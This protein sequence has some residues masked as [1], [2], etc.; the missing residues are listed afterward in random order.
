MQSRFS[1]IEINGKGLDR[2]ERC[3][4]LPLKKRAFSRKLR[5]SSGEGGVHS[6]PTRP[7]SCAWADGRH[8]SEIWCSTVCSWCSCRG[9]GKVDADNADNADDA[10]GAERA[11]DEGEDE[12]GGGAPARKEALDEPPRTLLLESD[13]IRRR[14]STRWSAFEELGGRLGGVGGGELGGGERGRCVSID[15]VCTRERGAARAYNKAMQVA[16][17]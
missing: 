15:C 5:A 8:L 6:T 12:D 17:G 1:A 10:D 2:V 14:V 16:G 11:G 9:P 4:P 13:R 3:S 7:G